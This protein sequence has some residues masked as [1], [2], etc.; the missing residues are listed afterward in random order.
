MSMTDIRKSNT[1][2]FLREYKIMQRLLAI[3]EG[4]DAPPES[5][6]HTGDDAELAAMIR[7]AAHPFDPLVEVG[8]IRL[9]SQTERIT[10]GVV[11]KWDDLRALV[12]PMSRYDNP[13]D[14][15]EFYAENA[16]DAALFMRVYQLW[17]A[18]TLQKSLLSKTWKAGRISD[19]ELARLK[20][21]L[22]HELLGEELPRA[23]L[24]RSG[25]GDLRLSRLIDEYQHEEL[26]NF[27]E[28]D[29]EDMELESLIEELPAFDFRPLHGEFESLMAAAG[30]ETLSPVFL[31]KDKANW[32]FLAGV[33]AENFRKVGK[34]K[35]LPLFS[36][37]SD[38]IAPECGWRVVAFRAARTKTLL[39]AGVIEPEDGG[40]A[41]RL[42]YPVEPGEVP[43]LTSPADIEIIIL[44]R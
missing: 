37:F 36:W 32:Q 18:R 7:N 2:K 26:E 33:E 35:P 5:P 27:S 20:Q 4:S 30:K 9:F 6:L 34:G 8:D 12:V 29:R 31:R 44:E 16:T 11:L 14:G 23:L 25:L 22:R 10:Y 1:G 39:G 19:A 3:P 41:I 38:A 28:L 15:T 40:A 24:D 17:N 21:M 42:R 13:A 43:A